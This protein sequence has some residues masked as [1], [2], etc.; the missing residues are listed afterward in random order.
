M[1]SGSTL[2]TITDPSVL[3]LSADVDETDVL[4]V[5]RGVGAS[6]EL[7]A[8]PD[9]TYH[10]VVKL[11]GQTP[12]TSA[13]GGVTYRVRL[14][15]GSG[16]NANGTKAPRPRPGM[17]A[18]VN[19]LVRHVT[20]GV[21]VPAAAVIHEG[22]RDFVWVDDNGVAKKAYIEVGAQGDDQLQVLK[23]VT[24]GQRIVVR[25]AV[26]VTKGQKLPR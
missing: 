3:T 7:D 9:A 19:M 8:V 24:V 6:V 16:R 14:S 21:R 10:A 25:D 15:L 1:S 12:T 2:A 20:H 22:N 18:V 23:G 5:H 4:L 13:E 17:S 26:N 11:I